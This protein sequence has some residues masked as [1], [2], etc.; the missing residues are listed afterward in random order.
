[1]EKERLIL[2][3]DFH[4]HCFPDNLAERAISSLQKAGNS[5]PFANGTL[6]DLLKTA[7]DAN[8]DIS[9][10][11]PIAVKPQNTATINTFAHQNNGIGG[12]ISFGSVHPLC[13]DYKAELDKIKYEYNLKGIKIHPDFMGINLDD[14][15][16]ADMLSYAVKLGL[17]ITIHSGLDLSYKNNCRRSTPKMLYNIL[18]QLKGGKIV[19]AHSGGYM[20][21]D[22]FLKYLID[23]DE[24]YIDTSYSLGYMDDNILRKIYFSM[25]PDHI[26][27]G[28]DS[29]WTNR[30]DAVH[31]IN[32]FGFSEEMKNKIFYKNAMKLLEI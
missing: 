7:Q 26:L 11:L 17:I 24:I 6:D 25:N 15:R 23:K 18:S 30:E 27:F 2:I 4:T 20:Y 31:R 22:E 1:M 16:M 14:P 29:P 32:S 9:V 3:I 5:K 8:I 13:E 21:S 28:T 12:I 19:M 10:I